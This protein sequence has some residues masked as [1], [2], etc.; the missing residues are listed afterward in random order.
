MLSSIVLALLAP[1]VPT[2]T[3][4]AKVLCDWLGQATG[5]PHALGG[6][7]RDYPVFL[8]VRSGEP[9]RVKALVA[10]ALA[11]V[12]TQ[13][14]STVRLLPV[15]PKADEGLVEFA[16]GWKA[17]TAAR[18][19]FAALPARELYALKAGEIL[20]FGTGE[21]PYVRPLPDALR[22][23]VDASDV[24]TGWVYV[25]RFTNG[26]FETKIEMPDER[27]GVFSGDTQVDFRSLPPEVA[28]ALGDEAKKPVLSAADV[29]AIGKIMANPGAAK[30]DPKMI[31]RADPLARFTDPVLMPLA[32]ALK[33]DLVVALPD[34]AV[35]GLMGEKNA[36]VE[37]TMRAF[38]LFDDWT[39]ANGAF[40][41]RLPSSER[42]DR[43]QTRRAVMAEFVRSARE[44]GVPGPAAL[45]QYLAGQRP[46]A[47]EGW[48][49]VMMLVMSGVALDQTHVGD[50]P[51]NLRLGA[52]LTDGDWV[53]LRSGKAVTMPELSGGARAALLT[54]LVQSRERMGSD[55]SDPVQWRDFPNVPLT[56]SSK[57]EEENVVLG[58]QGG[59][60]E[61]IT[62]KDA[63]YGYRRSK[64][65][66]EAEPLYRPGRRRKLT[67]TVTNP[68]EGEP[69]NTGFADVTVDPRATAV[70]WTGLPAASRKAFE[71]AMKLKDQQEPPP[72]ESPR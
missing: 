32:A 64:Q 41:G 8:S 40:V 12:W 35:M 63:G 56:I 5:V 34:F 29:A 50:Y 58:F 10:Q 60:T 28:T 16:R 47:S 59:I 52:A 70:P 2:G 3:T 30:V 4:T 49:D 1:P 71:A 11:G 62:P 13:D 37:T 55:G 36:T 6:E 33:E 61:V 22:K 17:A 46:Q 14:G 51:F 54:L 69:V 44:V 25:R 48:T 31:D 53:R 66:L 7:L 43:A 68:A 18:P 21:S 20:R 38:C 19:N 15:R 24:R 9:G 27:K 39:V 23:K 42:R 26:C 45:A 65:A 57:V 72:G 67:L